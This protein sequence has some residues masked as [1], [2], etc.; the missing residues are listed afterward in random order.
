MDCHLLLPNEV[1][2]P[3]SFDVMFTS[4][5]SSENN[6][7]T[8]YFCNTSIALF[9]LALHQQLVELWMTLSFFTPW[10]LILHIPC[11]VFSGTCWLSNNR[12][13][14]Y[15]MHHCKPSLLS[16]HLLYYS[17]EMSKKTFL[18]CCIWHL[19]HFRWDSKN[20]HWRNWY[21]YNCFALWHRC[22]LQERLTQME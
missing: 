13:L 21:S 19:R 15:F 1:S 4:R 16:S 17:R 10:S 14:H 6:K 12:L 2:E 8:D 11:S 18:H 7:I 3:F 22:L 20:S 5:N 9:D